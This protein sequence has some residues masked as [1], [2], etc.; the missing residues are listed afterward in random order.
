[1]NTTTVLDAVRGE[2]L[3]FGMGL[4]QG[5]ET[6]NLTLAKNLTSI[7]FSV[8]SNNSELSDCSQNILMDEIKVTKYFQTNFLSTLIS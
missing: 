7:Y 5:S 4:D 8:K 6:S 3:G 1:M 2:E